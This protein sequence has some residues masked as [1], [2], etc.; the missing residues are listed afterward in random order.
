MKTVERMWRRASRPREPRRIVIT[1][2]LP[3]NARTDFSYRHPLL[4]YV[5]GD[6][7]RAFFIVGCLVLDLFSPLQ[8]HESFPGLDLW[9]LPPLVAGLGLLSYAEYRAYQW[10]WPGP[11]RREIVDVGEGRNP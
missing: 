8:V 10:L 11:R 6:V 7:V 3:R 4:A 1:E 2:Q 5:F 9:L